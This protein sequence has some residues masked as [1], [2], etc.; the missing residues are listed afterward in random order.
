MGGGS[1]KLHLPSSIIGFFQHFADI[2]FSKL[3]CIIFQYGEGGG[4]SSKL[5]LQPSF[6]DLF[7]ALQIFTSVNW[8]V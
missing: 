4:I 3:F 1:S 6:I 8:F 2:Y 7:N 5:Y